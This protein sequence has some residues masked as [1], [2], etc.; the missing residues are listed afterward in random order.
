[1]KCPYCISAIDDA[2]SA[3]PHCTRDL[4]LLRPLLLKIETLEASLQ[5]RIDA[6]AQRLPDLRG[7][8]QCI[9][10]GRNWDVVVIDNPLECSGK[11][12]CEILHEYCLIWRSRD[13]MWSNVIYAM[14]AVEPF[15]PRAAE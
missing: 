9:I 3:C 14:Y 5:A 10:T 6:L 4:T 8:L 12:P 7:I 15:V 13:S 2:A 1:M 11:P